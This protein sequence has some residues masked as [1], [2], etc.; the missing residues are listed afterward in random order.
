MILLAYCAPLE[1][2]R[3]GREVALRRP[4]KGKKAYENDSQLEMAPIGRDSKL[5]NGVCHGR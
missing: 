3:S 1:S 4:T 5:T 2:V